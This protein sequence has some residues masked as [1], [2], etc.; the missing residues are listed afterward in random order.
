MVTAVLKT[1]VG[2]LVTEDKHEAHDNGE[3]GD[4]AWGQAKVALE[5][6]VNEDDE[7]CEKGMK[8][9]GDYDGAMDGAFDKA[10]NQRPSSR[11]MPRCVGKGHRQSPTMVPSGAVRRVVTVATSKH[12]DSV[13]LVNCLVSID[14][15]A[16]VYAR[17]IHCRIANVL[18]VT[19]WEYAVCFSLKRISPSAKGI[20]KQG[21]HQTRCPNDYTQD[22][23][24]ETDA[25][26][27]AEP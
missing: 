19:T 18:R 26:R 12:E 14:W 25:R 24:K 11:L 15:R 13:Y 2:G 8:Q 3:R 27:R 5:V 9:H 6:S 22:L 21:K 7:D 23:C 1:I 10:E 20:L 4:D 17:R 16:F